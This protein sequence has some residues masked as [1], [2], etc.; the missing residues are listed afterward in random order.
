MRGL[1][2]INKS[3][4]DFTMSVTVTDEGVFTAD[5]SAKFVSSNTFYLSIDVGGQELGMLIAVTGQSVSVPEYTDT[6]TLVS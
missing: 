5:C 3:T 6:S 1:Y 2:Y 4:Y